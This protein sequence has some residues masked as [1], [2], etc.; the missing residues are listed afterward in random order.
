M[1]LGCG[2]SKGRVGVGGKQARGSRG[3]GQEGGGLLGMWGKQARG[4]RQARWVGWVGVGGQQGD[5]WGVGQAR[6]GLGCEASN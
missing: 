3:V 2:A 1:G 5:G 4:V 6:S